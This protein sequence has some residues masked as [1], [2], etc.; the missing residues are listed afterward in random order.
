MRRIEATWWLFSVGVL[1]ALLSGAVF[2]ATAWT[3]IS[4]RHQQVCAV[5]DTASRWMICGLFYAHQKVASE[6]GPQALEG[7]TVVD[8]DSGRVRHAMA[9]IGN[10]ELSGAS[11]TVTEVADALTGGFV[12]SDRG[13]VE[14]ANSLMLRRP[15][16]HGTYQGPV[17]VL[18]HAYIN[19][20]GVW[21]FKIEGD[22]LLIC[23]RS[24]TCHRFRP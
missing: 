15:V 18:N 21:Q 8:H 24:G 11:G 14:Q 23:H 4:A 12:V 6:G 16:A 20:D 7:Y 1:F 3:D 22:D 19:L 5:E 17:N 9:T 10:M 13:V 2:G